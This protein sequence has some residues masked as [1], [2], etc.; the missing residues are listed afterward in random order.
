MNPRRV[1][2]VLP[3]FHPGASSRIVSRKPQFTSSAAVSADY[4]GRTAPCERIER[5]THAY[6]KR[7]HI[8]RFSR[9]PRIRVELVEPAGGPPTREES[10][11]TPARR[12]MTEVR[13]PGTTRA[14]GTR[15][16]ARAPA[17]TSPEQAAAD[18]DRS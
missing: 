15:Q 10:V 11:I 17:N 18:Q 16:D 14:T 7:V 3:I 8:V 1:D 2:L 12:V 4:G 5:H 6:A 9:R 13:A